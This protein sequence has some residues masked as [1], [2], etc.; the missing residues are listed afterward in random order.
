ML[1]RIISGLH[2]SIS[3]QLSY[4]YA[5]KDRDDKSY[6]NVK[7]FFKKVGDY[8]NRIRNLFF[9]YSVL[10]RAVNIAEKFIRDF[11]YDTGKYDD[12]TRT[13]HYI[14]ELLDNTTSSCSHSFE[15][16]ELFQ[17]ISD[18]IHITLII[19]ELNIFES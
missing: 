17:N 18:V 14:K 7:L 4:N 6:P 16:N 8:P 19:L 15:E 1:Y 11:E 13:K 12:D 5:D 9:L 2:S 3:T 10:M